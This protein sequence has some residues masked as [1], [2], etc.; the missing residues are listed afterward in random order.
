MDASD[1]LFTFRFLVAEL[2]RYL[3]TVCSVVSDI[4][5]YVTGSGGDE[6]VVRIVEGKKNR[7]D[8]F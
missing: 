2:C 8:C 6:G 3:L 5:G 7:R 4:P 1:I